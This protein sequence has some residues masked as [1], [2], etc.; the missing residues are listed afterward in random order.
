MISKHNNIYCKNTTEN[1]KN[2]IE[3]YKNTT[4]N[5]CSKCSKILSSKY[6]LHKHLLI[7]KGV[8]NSLECHYCHKILANSGSKCAHLKICKEKINKE[9]KNKEKINNNLI[10]FDKTNEKINFDVSHLDKKDYDKIILKVPN[11]AFEYYYYI[12]FDND[13]NKFI[14]K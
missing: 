9:N 12:L 10:L 2:T 13:N 4:E 1:C 3:N 11:E 8:L 6:Y 5:K 14:I 7:C